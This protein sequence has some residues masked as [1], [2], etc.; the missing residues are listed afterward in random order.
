MT[1]SRPAPAPALQLLRLLAEDAPSHDVEQQAHLL[2]S[3]LSEADAA[4]AR[5]LALRIK[6]LLDS[7]RRR[8]GELAALVDTARELATVE[9][10]GGVLD[11]IVRR[12]RSLL[13]TDTAYLTLHDPERGDTMMRAT[14]GSV[15]AAFQRVRLPLGAGLGGLVAETR[16][17]WWTDDYA[18]DSRFRHTGEIDS[19]VG[20]EGLVAIC[21][22]PLLVDDEFVGVLFA[23]N[24]VRRPFSADEVALLGSLATLAAVSLVQ[25]RTLAEARSSSA[26]I[27]KAA[28]AHD[29]FAAVVLE[30]GGV[31]D[32][33]AVLRDLLGGWV[34]VLDA[35]GRRAVAHGPAPATSGTA[36]DPDPL[37]DHPVVRRCVSTGRLAD[38]D[39]LAAVPATASGEQLGTLV[40]APPSPLDGGE[41]R[42]VERAAVVAALVL[43][44]RRQAAEAEQRVRTDLLSDLLAHDGGDGPDLDALRERGRLLGVAL[45]DEHV[46][47]VCT[48]DPSALRPVA[49]SASSLLA[50]QGLVAVHRGHVVAL[51]PATHPLA[52]AGA[53]SAADGLARRLGRSATVTVGAAGPVVPTQGVT[54]AWDEARRTSRALVALGTPGRGASAAD[55]GFAGLV[56]GEHPDVAGYLRAQLGPVLDYDRAR[57]TDLERTLS[58]YFRAGGSP[59]HAASA[60]HVHVNT[61]T[62]RLERVRA[63]I[64]EDWQ[65]PER[66][67]ELQLALRLREVLGT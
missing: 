16:R 32:V 64:G 14:A 25:T 10:P 49:L 55:L 58:A 38:G 9:D 19:A 33:T 31:D 12:A 40:L 63:L 50:G 37:T 42:I 61:V 20:E 34:V 48:V 60:L 36:G 1:P 29:R 26:S 3:D 5:D 21:G 15:S 65:S 2:A 6:D 53:S 67:L 11:A 24:R 62:Q 44:F 23:S 7:R 8:E 35:D 52:R 57:G 51:V 28:E 66:V 39:G 46:V 47:A 18:H 30:G 4:D 56:V 17:P 45:D 54:G 43:L 13:G 27:S 41:R 22:T 59:R